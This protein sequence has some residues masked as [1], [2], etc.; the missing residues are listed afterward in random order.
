MSSREAKHIRP[1]GGLEMDSGVTVQCLGHDHKAS[2]LH[3]LGVHLESRFRATLGRNG[4]NHKCHLVADPM[5][6][7][8]PAPSLCFMGL[9]YLVEMPYA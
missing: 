4:T 2:E 9:N 5:R 1:D 8:Q 6:D 3:S 7:S